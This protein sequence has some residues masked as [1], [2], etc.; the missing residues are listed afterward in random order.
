MITN[1]IITAGATRNNIDSMR[2][3][4]ANS[5]GRTGVLIAE[6]FEQRGYSVHLL[7]SPLA[8]LQPNCPGKTEEYSSTDDLLIKLERLI[9]KHPSSIVIHCAAVGDFTVRNAQNLKIPS[10]Q[11]ITLTLHPTPKILDR[12]KSWDE[13][14]TLASFKAAAPATTNEDLQSICITQLERTQSDVVLGNVLGRLEE[15]VLVQTPTHSEWFKNRT[16]GI[17]RLIDVL[18]EISRTKEI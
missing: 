1:V 14:V 2:V 16:D 10:G 3:I 7:G 8:L 13:T 11:A 9:K 15:D 6:C 5:S 12:I 18:E 17:I 4:T